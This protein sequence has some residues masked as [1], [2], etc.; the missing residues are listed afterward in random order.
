MKA[1]SYYSVRTGGRQD[2][3][4]EVKME[5]SILL[6]WQIL[7]MFLMLLMGFALVKT[8]LLKAQDSKTLSVLLLYLAL[9]CAILDSFQVEY[10]SRILRGLML[11]FAAAVICHVILLLAAGLLGK[12]LHLTAVEKASVIYSN[13]SNLIIP[14]ITAVLGP[15][16]VVYSTAYVS[17]QLL[18]LWTHGKVL[19]SGIKGA[20]I[21]K[22]LTNINL[23]AVF[24]GILLF[25]TGFRLPDVLSDTLHSVGSMVAP[26]SMFI[27][28]M[29]IA[30]MRPKQIFGN[31]RAYG[32]VCLRMLVFP[33]VSLLLLRL[34]KAAGAGVFGGAQTILLITLLAAITPPASAVIQMSQVYGQD[35][36]Y[37]GV[38]NVL[39]TLVC[40]I[41]MPVTVLLYLM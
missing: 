23:L 14:I 31:R 6:F 34:L 30:G 3:R 29:L 24:A 5:I 39:S 2:K 37:A 12:A 22:I 15:E 1:S 18:L 33:A 26:A 25:L 16:W 13:S 8:G 41:T 17:V 19:L 20:D 35:S 27:A 4:G 38:L 10:D 9:P 36:E 21:R 28:G 11:A 32:I 40:I 7:S